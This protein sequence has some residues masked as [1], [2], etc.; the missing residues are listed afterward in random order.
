MSD[1]RLRGLVVVWLSWLSGMQRRR[2]DFLIGGGGRGG[3]GGGAQLSIK[4]I[5]STG[6]IE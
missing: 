6:H 2:K 3:G 4:L 1:W 5:C